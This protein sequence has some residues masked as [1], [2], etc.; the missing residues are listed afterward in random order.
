[1]AKMS[2]WTATS[3]APLD[4]VYPKDVPAEIRTVRDDAYE[5]MLVGHDLLSGYNKVA[6]WTTAG[7][8][9]L[10]TPAQY[11]TG[12]N[13]DLQCIEYNSGTS[14]S[15]VWSPLQL[16]P[17][18]T[19][20]QIAALWTSASS[21]KGVHAGQL[22]YNSDTLCFQRRNNTGG[23][24]AE[25]TYQP[26]SSIPTY[27]TVT[28][29]VSPN[30]A[31]GTIIYNSTLGWYEKYTGTNT[32]AVLSNILNHGNLQGNTTGTFREYVIDLS[33]TPALVPCNI[34]INASVYTDTFKSQ[35]IV[36]A[37]SDDDGDNY[38]TVMTIALGTLASG[39]GFIPINYV[40]DTVAIRTLWKIT[41]SQ[42]TIPTY[43]ISWEYVG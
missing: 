19:T 32:W 25:P 3:T 9:A 39:S 27:T 4:T 20:A 23:E 42:G 12:Y 33:A 17:Y 7:R 14:A 41:C 35:N 8:I 28:R 24:T 13:S 15:P 34:R 31:L 37:Y 18:M 38:T 26:L 40:G 22:F 29:P 5:T 43:S 1:M 6:V 11:T 2:T 21:Y 10:T 36:L 16:V 30:V